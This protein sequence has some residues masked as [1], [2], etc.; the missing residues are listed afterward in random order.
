MNT[1]KKKGFTLIELMIVLAI[2]AI[3]AVV[4]IPKSGIFKSQSK[5][6]GVTTNVNTVRAYLETKTSD[7]TGAN[8]Y[9]PKTKLETAL[10]NAFNLSA[11]NVPDGSESN[12]ELVN[13]FDKANEPIHVNDKTTSTE[14]NTTTT[15][16]KIPSSVA[17]ILSSKGSADEGAV[18]IDVY[19]DGY[20]LYGIDNS[21][22]VMQV[23]VVK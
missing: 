5:N 8:T 21:G 13:P 19:A 16:T 2:I 17:S 1:I 14:N 23:Y 22:S 7:A 18:V 12:N 20:V 4:L 3:L 11:S 15:N 9:L 6:T 10:Q